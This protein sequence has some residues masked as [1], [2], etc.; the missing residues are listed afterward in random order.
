MVVSSETPTI[1]SAG[2]LMKFPGVRLIVVTGGGEVV[3]A[4][5]N[6]GK[7][8]IAA[9]P[10]NPPVVVD[11]TAD[12]AAAA[13]G[14]VAGASFDNNII[15]TDEKLVLAVDKIADPTKLHKKW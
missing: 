10:G 3:R 7:K 1:A 11:E 2:E 12:L 14:I 15:C 6:S 8:C 13:R 4:A 9:G 5:M